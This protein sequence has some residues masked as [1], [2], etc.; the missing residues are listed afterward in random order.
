MKIMPTSQGIKATIKRYGGRTSTVSPSLAF[1]AS[2]E[3]KT[4]SEDE[5]KSS[6]FSV[7]PK[8][9]VTG[10]YDQKKGWEITF[11]KVIKNIVGVQLSYNAVLWD[12]YGYKTMKLPGGELGETIAITT[13]MNIMVEKG[14]EATSTIKA[15]GKI[16][17]DGWWF[18][19]REKKVPMIT[20]QKYLIKRDF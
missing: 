19:D 18:F 12:I 2:F 1:G 17:Q 4:K 13:G 14:L 16:F 10:S 5:T 3:H 8:L 7:G 6:T 20:D 9:G 11:D 15:E